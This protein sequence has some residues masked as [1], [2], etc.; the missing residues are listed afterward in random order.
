M[1]RTITPLGEIK[2]FL[3]VAWLFFYFCYLGMTKRGQK[4]MGADWCEGEDVS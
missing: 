1:K 3:S 2:N 4:K